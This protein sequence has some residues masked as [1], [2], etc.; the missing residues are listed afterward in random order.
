MPTAT[1]RPST[2]A[3]VQPI[4]PGATAGAWTPACLTANPPNAH[5]YY[6]KFYTFTLAARSQVTITLAAADPTYLYLLTG[7][8]PRGDIARESG[9]PPTPTTTLT[10]TLPSGS[11]TIEATTYHPNIT[12]DF[13]LSLTIAP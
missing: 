7:A 12:G 3:C 2:A 5:A 9:E 1:P 11:Y 8:G 6:A 13:T 10:A 4:Q